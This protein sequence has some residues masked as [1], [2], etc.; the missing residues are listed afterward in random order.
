MASLRRGAA[1]LAATA[2]IA[3]A[4]A[5]S[6]HAESASSPAPATSAAQLPTALYGKAD[7]TYDGVWRQSL[8][9]LALNKAQVRPAD[10]AVVWL[11]D[12]Q[13]A[14]GGWASY[15]TDPGQPCAAK[16]EDSNAT[17]VAI[18]ALAALGGHNDGVARGAKWLGDV[19]NDDGGWS[20]NP[21]Q[22]SDGN[23]TALAIGALDAAGVAPTTV[24]QGGK[25]PY[26]ALGSLQLGCSAKANQQGAFAYQS[27]PK[28]KLA[29]N[30][31]ATAQATLAE[32]GMGLT[33]KQNA[34][35]EADPKPLGCS[36]NKSAASGNIKTA[37]HADAAAAYLVAR[38]DS[39]GDHL[40]AVTPGSDK[41]TPDYSSTANAAIA[42]AG[43]GY[44]R[45]AEPVV[46]WLAQEHAAWSK[47]QPAA[48]AQLILVAKATG[49]NPRSFGGADLVTQLVNAGPAAQPIDRNQAQ[50]V[51]D[52]DSGSGF[53]P[54][55]IA[56]IG[57][58][59]GIGI[60]LLISLRRRKQG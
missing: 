32:Y 54:W 43:G 23:S 36:G 51:S 46:T 7:P 9:L 1:A 52:A 3:G 21:G 45:Q 29:A 58:L 35:R 30:D 19:Q 20:Y 13:C 15:R 10:K 8:S 47:D 22:A 56:G 11:A 14:D 5:Q 25:S 2:L 44:L 26:D 34:A 6:A 55:W 39:N 16:A 38:L 53:S 27:D 59:V 18:Q 4:A 24:K 50:E 40:D 17:A 33:S 57:L 48:L 60:G 12:Q 37:A 42:L 31:N 41:A 49:Q 28:G